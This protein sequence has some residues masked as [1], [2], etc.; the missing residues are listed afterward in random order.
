MGKKAFSFNKI[1]AVYGLFFNWQ[2]KNYRYIFNNTK[3]ELDF[4]TFQSIIDIGCGTGALC[5]VLNEYGLDV[6]GLDPAEAMLAVAQRKIVKT[7]PNQKEIR[8]IHDNVLNG[9]TF[10]DKSFDLAIS[11]YVAHGLMQKERHTLYSEMQRVAK[12]T[13]ILFDYTSNAH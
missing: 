13:A 9:L 7:E 11:S 5:K 4:L 1:A 2:V 6:T 12:H 8:L 10:R 3:E